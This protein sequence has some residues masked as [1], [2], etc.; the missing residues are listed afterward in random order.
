MSN[1]SSVRSQRQAAG[2]ID[3]APLIPGEKTVDGMTLS[4]GDDGHRAIV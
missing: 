4:D 2:A 1:S 3:P